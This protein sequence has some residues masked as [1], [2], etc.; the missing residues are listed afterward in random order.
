LIGQVLSV[1]IALMVASIPGMVIW[2]RQALA[3][4]LSIA[5]MARCGVI[6]PPA[7]AAALLFA[8]GDFGIVH[9]VLLLLGN[10]VAIVIGA[11]I[12]NLS[13]K[14]Q[15]PTYIAMGLNPKSMVE[16]LKRE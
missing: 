3:T 4:S 10:V 2:V 8:S 14:R 9:M 7:G 1:S 16:Y 5:V 15:Y 13:E 11:L 12:N 6:H